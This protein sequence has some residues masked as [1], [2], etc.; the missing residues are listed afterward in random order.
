MHRFDQDALFDRLAA[1]GSAR[2]R[3][4]AA[5]GRRRSRSSTCEAERRHDHGGRAAMA[6]VIDGNAAGF[7]EYGAGVL[8]AGGVR[9]R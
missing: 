6:W 4:D 9:D 7:A 3:T 8:D 1:H 2:C 5:A